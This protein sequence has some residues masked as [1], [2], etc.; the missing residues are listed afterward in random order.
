MEN[1]RIERKRFAGG[2]RF[3]RF[4]GRPAPVL[5][6]R[7]IPERVLIPLADPAGGALVPMVQPGE[8]VKAGQIVGGGE[9]DES[10]PAL[11]TVSG[12]VEEIREIVRPPGRARAVVIRSDGSPRWEPLGG[13]GP[14]WESLSAER[15]EGLIYS[16]GVSSLVPAGLPT[17][18]G[19]SRLEPGQVEH[20]IV[21]ETESEVYQPSLPVLL[22]GG[23][24]R[25]VTG[26]RIL[27]RILP[28]AELHLAF[29]RSRAG[30]LADIGAAL[31]GGIRLRG[32][33]LEPKYPQGR[34]EVLV[35]TLLGRELPYGR[36]AADLGILI[37]DV[38][39]VLHL[40]EA[41]VAGKPLLERVVSLS[42][43]GFRENP[44]LRVRIGTPLREVVD[45]YLR[46]DRALRIVAGGA[47]DGPA[48][49]DLD[50]PLEPAHANLI[51]LPEGAAGEP[52]FF[53][54]PGLRKDSY[55]RT[56][57][58]S[59]L[60]LARQAETNLHGEPRPCISCSYCEGVCPVGLLPQLLHRYVQRNL[61]EEILVRYRIFRCID[62]N[63]CTYVCPSKIPVARLL[64]EGKERLVAEGL[65]PA[66]PALPAGGGRASREVNA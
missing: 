60:P 37:L 56:F 15:L 21:Q 33:A 11:A 59:L 36:S 10:R 66:P 63:L 28:R 12:T 23:P 7:E 3:R 43:P 18:F 53:A 34:E 61:I 9:R 49:T 35:P 47:V 29:S 41:V 31:P 1:M 16:S 6:N 30:L 58:S 20:L 19:G 45:G 27:K 50:L 17:R 54:R 62:C 40:V 64:K 2:Y 52:L 13:H 57:L 44:H 5:V 38:Q 46:T 4:E 51:A 65:Q 14:A 55:S 48:L 42:G 24:Y 39:A 25:L 26:L 8:A 32:Y 22:S